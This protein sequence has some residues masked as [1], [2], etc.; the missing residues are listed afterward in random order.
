MENQK[1][2][3]VIWLAL[4][5]SALVFFFLTLLQI[6]YLYQRHISMQNDAVSISLVGA[7]TAYLTNDITV[8]RMAAWANSLDGY[9]GAAATAGHSQVLANKSIILTHNKNTSEHSVFVQISETLSPFTNFLS[10]LTDVSM[11]SD[12]LA[13]PQ[14][15]LISLAIDTSSSLSGYPLSANQFLDALGLQEINTISGNYGTGELALKPGVSG[16]EPRFLQALMPGSIHELTRVFRPWSNNANVHGPTSAMPTLPNLA[17]PS[18]VSYPESP[19]GGGVDLSTAAIGLSLAMPDIFTNYKFGATTALAILS[20][21]SPFLHIA[22]FG[23]MMPQPYYDIASNCISNNTAATASSPDQII[24]LPATRTVHELWSYDEPK[25]SITGVDGFGVCALS[26]EHPWSLNNPKDI[27]IDPIA[28]SPVHLY[29]FL[30]DLTYYYKLWKY[31]DIL[32]ESGNVQIAAG[33]YSHLLYPVFP[34]GITDWTAPPDA[35]V[36]TPSTDNPTERYSFFNFFGF[37]PG[38]NLLAPIGPLHPIDGPNPSSWVAASGTHAVSVSAY[39]NMLGVLPPS[40]V[41]L[42]EYNQ[43]TGKPLNNAP[44]QCAVAPGNP[45]SPIDCD[46]LYGAPGTQ[47]YP[48]CLPDGLVLCI[49]IGSNGSVGVAYGCSPN[50]TSNPY[51]KRG[52]CAGTLPAATTGVPINAGSPPGTLPVFHGRVRFP[53]NTSGNDDSSNWTFRTNPAHPAFA[54]MQFGLTNFGTW[55]NDLLREV[56]SKRAAAQ[57]VDPTIKHLLVLLTDGVPLAIND[58]GQPIK[59]TVDALGNTVLVPAADLTESMNWVESDF[60]NEVN[61]FT[62]NNGTVVTWF[63]NNNTVGYSDPTIATALAN[64]NTLFQAAMNKP[65][66]H[67]YLVNAQLTTISGS[68]TATNSTLFTTQMSQLAALALPEPELMQ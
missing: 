20:R 6:G 12:A 17:S 36:A 2:V 35:F 16:P 55:T 40:M 30:L 19:C 39:P 32:D 27:L 48:W 34:N 44:T 67:R 14:R 10:S 13:R 8:N 43:S 54:I 64:Q 62:N 66:Q 41:F 23:G 68:I 15:R 4:L 9:T 33:T 38:P 26:V 65:A 21:M 7:Q 63:V 58:Q 61:S 3:V 28:M 45:A 25:V 50:D 51:S 53:D 24:S 18:C 60:E 47:V 37:D 52:V 59:G 5:L 56:N 31:A 57:A 49:A 29:Q 46:T 11:V 22:A 1:G 42:N